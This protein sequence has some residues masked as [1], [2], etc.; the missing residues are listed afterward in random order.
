VLVYG[1]N[2]YSKGSWSIYNTETETIDKLFEL[3]PDYNKLEKGHFHNVKIKSKDNMDIEGFL[4]TPNKKNGENYPLVVIPHGGP[5]GVRDYAY[6]SDVQHFFASQ[7]IATLKVNYR[8]SGGYGKKFEESGKGQWGD[9]I[10]SDINQM[11]DHVLKNYDLSESKICAM[12]SSYGGYSAVMLSILYPDRYKCSVSLAGV[13]DLPLMFTSSDF[14]HNEKVIEDFKNIVGDPSKDQ[15][16]LL[17]KSPAYLADKINAPILL[18]HG[19]KDKRVTLEHSRRMKE[20]LDLK[21]KD[22]EL[23][24]FTNEGHS[25]NDLESEIVYIARALDFIKKSLLKN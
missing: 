12:G 25:F 24:V 3:N 4:V 11:V 20:V 6:N 18:F 21:N 16:I 5:I 17:A 19:A 22:S 15:Q 1:T 8:G 13:M 7:G 2:E 9:K 14:R 23:I 10:E